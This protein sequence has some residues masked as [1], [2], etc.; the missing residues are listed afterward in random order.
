MSIVFAGVLFAI[1]TI[2]LL[3]TIRAATYQNPHLDY[4][5]SLY[6]PTLVVSVGISIAAVIGEIIVLAS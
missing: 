4:R 1:A 3:G 6:W 2:F 5:P